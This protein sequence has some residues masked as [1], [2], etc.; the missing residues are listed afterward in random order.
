MRFIPSPGRL[1]RSRSLHSWRGKG[2]CVFAIQ[3]TEWIPDSSSGT[4]NILLSVR[5]VAPIPVHD[6]QPNSDDTGTTCQLVWSTYSGI[7][8]SFWSHT[9]WTYRQCQECS[10]TRD[11]SHRI[12]QHPTMIALWC[13]STWAEADG[14]SGGTSRLIQTGST[15]RFPLLG[16]TFCLSWFKLTRWVV[17]WLKRTALMNRPLRGLKSGSRFEGKF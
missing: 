9:D 1:L 5:K 12:W 14:D 3:R 4:L 6:S 17:G 8:S 15:K 2:T 16:R 7:D 10:F 13:S 11:Q